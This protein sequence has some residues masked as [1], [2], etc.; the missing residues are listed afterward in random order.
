VS[1][2][3]GSQAAA[4]IHSLRPFFTAARRIAAAAA[5]SQCADLP[6]EV[7][8]QAYVKE[9]PGRSCCSC[10]FPS[11]A[12]ELRPGKRGTGYLDLARIERG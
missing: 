9:E 11:T 12:R 2:I 5:R 4:G 3:P 10:A 6:P 7:L 1:R 8:L